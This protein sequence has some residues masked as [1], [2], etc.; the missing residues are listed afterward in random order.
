MD[1]ISRII[2][3]STNFISTG[4][5]LFG[6]FLVFLECFV[7]ALPLSVFVALNVNAF[8]IFIG[9]L[10][11]WIATCTGSFL[12]YLLFSFLEEKLVRRLLNKKFIVR[13]KKGIDKFQTI[14]FSQLVLIITLPFTPS[15]LINILS[16]L[17]GVSKEKFISALLIGKVFTVIFWGYIGKSFIESLLDF[18]SIIYIVVALIIAYVISKI[19]SHKMNIE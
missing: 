17:A 19:V 10:I 11:S 4:G 7:P 6:F 13:I 15:F 12:C 1:I 2:E 3:Y 9:V 18:D 5:V 14:T 8:G 16:G